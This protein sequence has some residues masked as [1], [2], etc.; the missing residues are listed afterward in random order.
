MRGRSRTSRKSHEN[1]WKIRDYRDSGRIKLFQQVL[2]S[3][4]VIPP[5]NLSNIPKTKS[6]V[7]K[8]MQPHLQPQK[9][10]RVKEDHGPFLFTPIN[11][12]SLERKNISK[13]KVG[14][15]TFRSLDVPYETNYPTL[16]STKTMNRYR[17]LMGGG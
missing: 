3:G 16:A 9:I 4:T 14:A 8:N 2:D 15:F 12:G 6:F 11:F 17:L 13:S 10:E 1:I 5:A 7:L